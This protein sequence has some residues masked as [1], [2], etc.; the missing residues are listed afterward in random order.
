MGLDE[1]VHRT[2]LRTEKVAEAF[3]TL[4]GHDVVLEVDAR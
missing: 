4:Q 2:R 1:I 3:E